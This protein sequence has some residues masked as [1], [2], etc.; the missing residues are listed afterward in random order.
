MD[1]ACLDSWRIDH[2]ADGR[3]HYE[4]GFRVETSPLIIFINRPKAKQTRFRTWLGNKL[5][6][7]ATRVFRS[8]WS[9]N[10]GDNASV[11]LTM[12]NDGGAEGLLNGDYLFHYSVFP[13]RSRLKTTIVIED[14][15]SLGQVEMAGFIVKNAELGSR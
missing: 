4:A 8:D 7:W 14:D 9:L 10:F 12:E 2:N 5:I 15:S 3:L 13:P 6:A 1:T 11:S